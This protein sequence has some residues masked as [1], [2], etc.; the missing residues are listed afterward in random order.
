MKHQMLLVA[1]VVALALLRS[2]LAAETLTEEQIERLVSQAPKF[3]LPKLIAFNEAK[4]DRLYQAKLKASGP[5][6]REA[7]KKA[8]EA[9]RKFYEADLVVGAMDTKG[10][11]GEAVFAME[12]HV[13][14]LRLRI[15]QLDTDFLQGWVAI[16]KVD[17]PALK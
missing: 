6:Y 14:Q 15:Y 16:P 3:H 9:W 2:L 13:Y 1:S 7:L 10:G 17:E 8:Q 4:L 11:S 12:R 5:E